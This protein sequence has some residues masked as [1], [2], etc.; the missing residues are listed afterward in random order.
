MTSRVTIAALTATGFMLAFTG[1]AF[2]EKTEET[3]SISD[4]SRIKNKGP[5]TVNVTV[6]PAT[7][8]T[9]SA[10]DDDMDEIITEVRGKTLH[11]E[12]DDDNW[13]WSNR[14]KPV[15]VT[16]TTPNLEEFDLRGSGSSVITGLEDT[17]FELEIAGSGDVEIED[18]NLR[19]FSV[20]IKGSGDVKVS[21]TCS[22]LDVEVKGSGDV[23]ARDM[24]CKDGEVGV[25]GSG[26][27]DA[28]VS[29]NAEVSIMGSGDVTLWGKP[30]TLDTRTMGSGDVTLR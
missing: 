8:L 11:I 16:V 6:G 29:G 9:V 26:D 27:V 23:D 19:A 24:K 4:F 21:G 1:S 30:S 13:G 18:A 2:A 7:S 25:M 20:D 28:Y 5:I 17:D 14:K 10:D 12:I 3:R 22:D 15:V